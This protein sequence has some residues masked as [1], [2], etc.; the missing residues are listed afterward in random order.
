MS[1]TCVQNYSGCWILYVSWQPPRVKFQMA[2][3]LCP[4]DFST[5]N[6]N[7]ASMCLLAKLHAWVSRLGLEV[8]VFTQ[9]HTQLNE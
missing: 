4:A 2:S 9:S 1:G 8:L 7:S 5:I 3:L 6:V